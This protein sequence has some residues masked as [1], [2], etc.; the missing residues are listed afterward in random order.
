MML[1]LRVAAQGQG[2]T[3]PNPMVG[4]VVV[5]NNRIVATGY[6]ARAG[7]PHAEVLA[8]KKAGRLTRHATLYVTLEPCCHTDKR[9]PPCVPTV[10]QSGVSRVVVAMR[11]PNPKV[12]GRGIRM[13]RSNGLQV[14]VGCL[15]QDARRLNTAYLHWIQTGRPFVTLKAAMT[16]DGQ[17][18]TARGESQWISGHEARAQGHR[19]RSHV[20]AILVGIKT[21]LRD[22]PQLTARRGTSGHLYA[23]QPWRVILDSRLS[24]PLHAKVLRP[25]PGKRNGVHAAANPLRTLL[26]TTTAASATRIKKLRSLGVVPLVVPARQNRVSLRACLNYLGKQGLHHVL[27]EGGGEVNGSALHDNLVNRV[28]LFIAP[29]LLG[30]QQSKGLLGGPSPARLG[31]GFY[32]KDLTVQHVGQDLLVEGTPIR[33]SHQ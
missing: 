33:G 4:A 16:L 13:L 2:T 14:T 12:T 32:L 22:D 26:I 7:T 25:L 10:L 15:E 31:D 9:T 23:H 29:T 21:V 30:G 6:H 8:L 24:I 27:I 17:I 19:L 5:S 3:S 20:D 1:A 28:A 18:A 11:D